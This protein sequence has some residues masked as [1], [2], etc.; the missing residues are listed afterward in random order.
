MRLTKYLVGLLGGS[1][2]LVRA[3]LLAAFGKAGLAYLDSIGIHPDA[4]MLRLIG[5]AVTPS[6][7][8]AMSWLI[9]AA[10]ALTASVAW[11][12]TNFTEV[13]KRWGN[14]VLGIPATV[15]SSPAVSASLVPPHNVDARSA[16]LYA[17]NG[18]WERR[19]SNQPITSETA[20][21]LQRIFDV[22]KL[23]CESASSETGIRVWGRTRAGRPLKLIEKTHWE[24][25]HIEHATLFGSE[26][27]RTVP[28]DKLPSNSSHYVD[29]HLNKTEVEALWPHVKKTLMP[30]RRMFPFADYHGTRL[31]PQ[32]RHASAIREQLEDAQRE[33]RQREHEQQA[34]RAIREV[35]ADFIFKARPIID[36]L[37]DHDAMPPL[38]AINQWNTSTAA[39]ISEKLGRE[40][41][42]RFTEPFSPSD[43]QLGV[44][45]RNQVNVLKVGLQEKIK[46]LYQFI[47]EL[48]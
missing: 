7:L 23:F 15:G 40:Y 47:E 48:R 8:E 42:A 44:L 21:E 35:L 29:I 36:D 25:W 11:E 6:S 20:K 24:D 3:V 30:P 4:W 18:T 9:A 26:P 39:Y 28:R 41:E 27:L 46:R 13:L 1:F 17:A 31:T 12:V 19:P 38:P 37:Q 14:R 32:E 16:L 22:L 33:R 5:Y 43:E 34:R 45:G 10:L 2:T